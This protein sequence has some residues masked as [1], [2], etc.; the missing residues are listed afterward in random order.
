[1]PPVRSSDILQLFDYGK[2]LNVRASL[3]QSSFLLT[4]NL[5]EFYLENNDGQDVCEERFKEGVYVKIY[6]ASFHVI[7]HLLT[8]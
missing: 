2:G 6:K 3:A 1:M 4:I 5:C 8:P 7:C